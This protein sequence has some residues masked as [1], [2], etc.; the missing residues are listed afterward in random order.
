MAVKKTLF[1]LALF[2]LTASLA[3]CQQASGPDLAVSLI[4]EGNA[5][6]ENKEYPK[7]AE[8]YAKAAKE[9]P[10]SAI[11]GLAHYN[12]AETFLAMGQ[13]DEAISECSKAIAIDPLMDM[14][15]TYFLRGE[16]YEKTG[17]Y[18][19]A[20]SDYCKVLIID[21]GDEMVLQCLKRAM[22]A[23]YAELTKEG[24]SIFDS[25]MKAYSGRDYLSAE[26]DLGGALSLFDKA[27]IFDK[28]DKTASGMGNFIKGLIY[29]MAA[30]KI[31]NVPYPKNSNDAAVSAL[32]KV[33]YPL[34]AANAYYD[35]ALL[36]LKDYK[37][38]NSVR[39]HKKANDRDMAMVVKMLPR[40]DKISG[41]YTRI[42]ELQAECIVNFYT[43]SE[44]LAANDHE[45]VK[46][47]LDKNDDLAA[48]LKKLESA[49]ADG[50]SR[51]SGAYAALDTLL[52]HPLEDMEWVTAN[53]ASLESELGACVSSLEAAKAGLK[54]AALL[55]ICSGLLQNVSDLRKAIGEAGK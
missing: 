29:R 25:G 10:K 44:L 21:S 27:R 38:S 5:C 19:N 22:R 55:K 40:L 52:S 15:I 50:I 18:M 53:K 17:K 49:D 28:S 42:T 43:A 12:R 34:A 6:Y 30:E 33:Y 54:N 11:A 2:S 4:K 41:D 32:K 7:A 3:A 48:K 23:E 1:L 47:V 24:M 13:Y 46:E 39:E 8:L 31:M 51:L 14:G 35:S 20:I 36:C 26:K 9:A 16:I 37:L 45:G